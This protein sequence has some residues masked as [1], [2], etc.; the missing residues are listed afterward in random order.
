MKK[1]LLFLA[2]LMFH[3]SALASLMIAP[4]RVMFDER[5]RSA[6]VSLI[7]ASSE[8][9]TYKI[10]WRHL[11]QTQDG[12]Y[13]EL[14]EQQ[15]RIFPMASRMVRFS[16]R[17]VT[18]K[19]QE[20]QSVRLSLRRPADLE[21]GEYRSHLAFEAIDEAKPTA[22]ADAGVGIQ[23]NINMAFSI[24][25][26]VRHQVDNVDVRIGQAEFF[27]I[28]QNNETKYL[29]Q[30]PLVNMGNASSFGSLKAYWQTGNNRFEQE[31]AGILN[32]V[33]LFTENPQRFINLSLNKMPN[34]PAQL[35]IVYEGGQELENQIIDEAI[36][37]F[38]PKAASAN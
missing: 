1:M 3:Q 26:L 38:T 34:A 37:N 18:L 4:T 30:F 8:T 2:A 16:P 22:N 21:P 36:V 6:K 11:M 14:T 10:Y 12:R 15:K 17:A 19:P 24:P 29:V 23:I 25:I 13:Q 9:K 20:R 33:S 28:L 27:N 35:K 31:P 5:T 32:N 7:N